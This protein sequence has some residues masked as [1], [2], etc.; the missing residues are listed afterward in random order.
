MRQDW[1]GKLTDEEERE[2]VLSRRVGFVKRWSM[3][4]L[5]FLPS[6]AAMMVPLVV[7]V[8]AS[9]HA[10]SWDFLWRHIGLLGPAM[11][12]MFTVYMIAFAISEFMLHWRRVITLATETTL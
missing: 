2:Y 11:L 8:R 5:S 3:W 7:T 9:D 4:L 10:G 1:R 6:L 12:A